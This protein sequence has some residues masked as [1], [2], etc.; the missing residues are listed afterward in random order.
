MNWPEAGP[1]LLEIGF[2][3]T[4]EAFA[5]YN[6]LVKEFTAMLSKRIIVYDDFHLLHNPVILNFI[7]HMVNTLAQ[8]STIVMLS[9]TEP[10]INLIGM[11]MT[12]NAFTIRENALCFTEHEIAEYF[13]QLGLSVTR[14]NIRD[15]Y[16]DT[17]GWAFA[18]NMIGRSLA[19]GEK[20]Y[21]WYALEAMK[22]NIFRLIERETARTISESL[23]RFFFFF[24]LTD[25]FTA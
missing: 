9:R 6:A 10:D 5:K 14:Q 20:K 11:T 23:W 7:E 24:S 12:D 21:E 2:P 8:N 16:D 4:D 3:E 1:R 15:I 17:Q 22:K 19:D 25:Y 13:S 18:V